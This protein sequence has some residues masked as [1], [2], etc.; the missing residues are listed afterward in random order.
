[1]YQERLAGALRILVTRPAYPRRKSQTVCFAAHPPRVQCR[2]PD[3]RQRTLSWVIG[4]RSALEVC[5]VAVARV[6]A[7]RLDILDGNAAA[8]VAKHH[9]ADR[10]GPGG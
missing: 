4:C 7:G 3:L 6:E 1:M 8:L 2:N 9:Q 5:A 10:A